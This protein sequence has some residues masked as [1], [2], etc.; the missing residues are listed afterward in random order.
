MGAR[1]RRRVDAGVAVTVIGG[2]LVGI[3]EHLVGFLRLLEFLL[4][5]F[6]LVL[7]IAVRMVFHRELAVSFLDRVVFGVAIDAQN[8]V[9]VS[10]GHLRF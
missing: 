8:L 4:R 3:G 7:R 2:A 9:I 10:L 6:A 5:A 1:C